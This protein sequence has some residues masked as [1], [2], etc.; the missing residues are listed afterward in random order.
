MR[1]LHAHAGQDR[2]SLN[3]ASC[4]NFALIGAR[5]R[6][7]EI[8]HANR[9]IRQR[10]IRGSRGSRISLPAGRRKRTAAR[11]Q[12]YGTVAHGCGARCA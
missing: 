3:M 1:L 7:V 9:F 5:G 8:L 10:E 6:I 4:D 11:W 2:I 12:K